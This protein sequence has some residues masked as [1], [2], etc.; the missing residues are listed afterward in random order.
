MLI[1]R[2]K[3]FFTLDPARH[4]TV[5]YGAVT[6]GSDAKKPLV[7]LIVRLLLH[8]FISGIRIRTDCP[9]FRSIVSGPK[10]HNHATM[11]IFRCCD[12]LHCVL[13]VN[14]VFHCLTNALIGLIS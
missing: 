9:R 13:Q 14:R 10:A 2:L 12:A 6:A 11:R 5:Q 3:G 1:K 7:R 4:G 8:C